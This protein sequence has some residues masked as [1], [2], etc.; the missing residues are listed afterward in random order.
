MDNEPLTF[1]LEQMTTKGLIEQNYQLLIRENQ[2]IDT[3][4]FP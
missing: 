2:Q 1:E 4:P 3:E